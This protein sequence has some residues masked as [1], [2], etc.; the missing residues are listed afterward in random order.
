MKHTSFKHSM[1]RFIPTLQLPVSRG[2]VTC[3]EGLDA[4]PYKKL[5]SVSYGLIHTDLSCDSNPEDLS[6]TLTLEDSYNIL[7]LEKGAKSKKGSRTPRGASGSFKLS[8]RQNC[9]PAMVAFST[10]LRYAVVKF[11][12]SVYIS[13]KVAYIDLWHSSMG[14]AVE[15]GKTR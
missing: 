2:L 15:H 3:S 4:Y 6:K 7:F 13:W 10:W 12:Y 14:W 5:A 1:A 9:K 11:E 8:R